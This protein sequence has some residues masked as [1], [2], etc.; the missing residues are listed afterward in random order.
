M[1]AI[2]R[3][4]EKVA[5]S[6]INV[7]ITGPNGV[8]KEKLA[9][10]VHQHSSRVNH[11]FIKVNMGAIPAEL[12]EAE[13][14]GAEQGAFTGANHQR[15]GRFEAASGG[16][17]MLDEIGNLSLQGQMKLLRVLQTGEFERLGSS[18]T[19]K[20]DVRVISATNESLETN[21]KKG[22]FREDLFYRLNVVQLDIPPLAKRKEI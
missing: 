6:D 21:V 17:L 4:A 22:T 12:M 10:F 19:I 3:Q 18:D 7:L 11:P 16:T 15:V 5:K 13:L 1:K 2:C 14:F 8:G 20:V 9:D